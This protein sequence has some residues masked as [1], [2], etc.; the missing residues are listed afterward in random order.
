M[1]RV[2]TMKWQKVLVAALD[3]IRKNRMRSA[4]TMLGI[5]IGVGAVAILVSVGQSARRSIEGNIASIGSNLIIVSPA[6]ATRD[7]VSA[8]AG[9]IM[10]LT[11][12]DVDAV[13]QQGT[14]ILAVS[15]YVSAP[16]QLIGGVGNWATQVQGTSP[17]YLEVRSWEIESGSFFTDREVETRAKVAVLGRTV[18]EELFPGR[19]PVG[20][21]IRIRNA[22]F[23][24]I[25]VLKAKGGGVGGADQDDVVLAPVTTVLYRLAGGRNIHVLWASARNADRMQQAEAQVRSILRAKHKLRNDQEDDFTL[26]NQAA[27]LDF[28]SNALG[29]LTLLLGAI[30]GISLLVGGI[31]IMNIMLVSVTERTREIG[32]RLAVGARGNDVLLQFL[33]EAVLLCLVG[34]AIGTAMSFGVAFVVTQASSFTMTVGWN[35]VMI[36][37]VFSAAIG[38]FFGFYPARRAALLDP[39]DALRHE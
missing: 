20:A 32:I 38:I 12:D 36:A 24:V 14:E 23:R 15:A 17:N 26:Q 33:V 1:M 8:G 37:V 6:K 11:L 27:I 21:Q 30:A 4:L 3:S 10:S 31:G 29:T 7:G 9:S 34:G 22:P 5:I 2:P 13:E 25:G 35:V 28:A 16:A 39:I 19:N 18:A